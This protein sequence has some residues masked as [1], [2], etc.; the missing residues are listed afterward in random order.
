MYKMGSVL[1]EMQAA[2]KL[3]AAGNEAEQAPGK[4]ELG[5]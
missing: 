1:E 4:L 2:A 5:H 3:A